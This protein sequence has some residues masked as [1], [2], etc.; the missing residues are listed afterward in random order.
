MSKDI[1]TRVHEIVAR[2]LE[3][4]VERVVPTA[5]FMEDLGADS[6]DVVELADDE[7]L[8]LAGPVPQDRGA[9]VRGGV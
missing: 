2:Q 6:L 9:L 8:P 4:A 7:V 1:E 3:V 5:R